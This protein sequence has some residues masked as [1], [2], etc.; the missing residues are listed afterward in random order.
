MHTQT[1][2]IVILENVAKNGIT[3]FRVEICIP[4]HLFTEQNGTKKFIEP[5]FFL[6]N[7]GTSRC[8]NTMKEALAE[9]MR[10]N[11]DNPT[12][13]ITHEVVRTSFDTFLYNYWNSFVTHV[14]PRMKERIGD[15]P[16]MLAASLE[17]CITNWAGVRLQRQHD[18]QRRYEEQ[19]SSSARDHE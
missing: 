6:D 7:F 13:E 16:E 4:G 8:W 17:R 5:V 11:R 9:S 12:L 15:N 10:I 2:A 14:L 19:R 1:Q 18:V 3:E